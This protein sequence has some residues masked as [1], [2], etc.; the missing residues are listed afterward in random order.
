MISAPSLR[1]FIVTTPVGLEEYTRRA[2]D[3]REK[4]EHQAKYWPSGSRYTPPIPDLNVSLVSI[5][6]GA[7][8]SNLRRWVGLLAS[9]QTNSRQDSSSLCTSVVS[10]M[11]HP[12]A[13]L[14]VCCT[15][16]NMPLDPETAGVM[17]RSSPRSLRYLHKDLLRAFLEMAFSAVATFFCCLGGRRS[18]WAI[19]SMYHLITALRMDYS[20]FP[21]RVFF[22]EMVYLRL[23]SAS[24]LGRNTRSIWWKRY[25][26][27]WRLSLGPPWTTEIKSY[28]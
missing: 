5:H 21:C 11:C 14:R 15:R 25:L 20:Q 26:S 24:L 7:K 3:V 9:L 2:W 12:A 19:V 23:V 27:I 6:V 18:R 17:L 13:L 4:G 10:W 22:R 1:S 16:V 8:G 28:R